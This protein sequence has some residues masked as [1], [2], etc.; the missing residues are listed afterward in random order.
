A[1]GAGEQVARGGQ[2]A[3]DAAVGGVRPERPA[4]PDGNEG[5]DADDEGRRLPQAPALRGR[6]AAWGN[7]PCDAVA[8]AAAPSPSVLAAPGP[9]VGRATG[10]GARGA[11][12]APA[13]S[14]PARKGQAPSPPSPGLRQCPSTP[15][16]P[17][18][19]PCPPS[20]SR[21]RPW[22]RPSS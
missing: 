1:V 3:V 20:A 6:G 16:L 4:E 15:T 10:P 11:R 7:G 5:A 14:A 18:S 21:S 22:T 9:W 2:V 12:G 19:Q 17:R 8:L 13:K